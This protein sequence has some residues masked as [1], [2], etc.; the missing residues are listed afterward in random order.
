M[1]RPNHSNKVDACCACGKTGIPTPK[2]HEKPAVGD[3][4]VWQPQANDIPQWIC[5]PCR[6]RLEIDARRDS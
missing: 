3:L 1:R 5:T 4:E 6:K 2:D